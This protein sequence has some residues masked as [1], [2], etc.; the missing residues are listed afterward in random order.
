MLTVLDIEYLET[1]L[2]NFMKNLCNI[3]VSTYSENNKKQILCFYFYLIF[4][5]LTLSVALPSFASHLNSSTATKSRATERVK[6]TKFQNLC[7]I[8][9][10]T[11]TKYLFLNLYGMLSY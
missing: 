11:E 4:L 3:Q 6:A 2:Q 1:L 7:I 9:L 10:S 8:F 5:Q